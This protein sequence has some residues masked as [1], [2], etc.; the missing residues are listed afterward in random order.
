LGATSN[1]DHRVPDATEIR[2]AT[3]LRNPGFKRL[4]NEAG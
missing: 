1:P 4:M 3:T 2:A